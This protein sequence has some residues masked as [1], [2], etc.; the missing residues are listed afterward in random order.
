METGSKKISQWVTRGDSELNHFLSYPFILGPR[1]PGYGRNCTHKL[2]NK[3]TL[4]IDTKHSLLSGEPTRLLPP[5]TVFSEACSIFLSGQLLRDGGEHGRI[6]LPWA[7]SHT[8]LAMKYISWS[9]TI[10][11]GMPWQ[12]IRHSVSLWAV[13]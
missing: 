5:V 3:Q 2:S 11:C 6:P 12:R 10:L 7:Y 9:E 13:V 1:D 8:S 4:G